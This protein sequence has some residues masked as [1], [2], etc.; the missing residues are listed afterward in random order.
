[1]C[2][3][4]KQV[5]PSKNV[6]K[7]IVES[8]YDAELYR[9]LCGEPE[10]SGFLFEPPMAESADDTETRN[11]RG[12][13]RSVMDT[14]SSYR[15]GYGCDLP[16]FGL[17][18]GE[19]SVRFG[20]GTEL[21]ECPDLIFSIADES[22][23]GLLFLG[24]FE[25]ENLY[26]RY[27][28]VIRMMESRQRGG[29]RPGPM[30]ETRV[31]LQPAFD[32]AV[33][34]SI[35]RCAAKAIFTRPALFNSIE[36][37]SALE[38]SAIGSINRNLFAEFRPTRILDD[39]IASFNRR[40]LQTLFLGNIETICDRLKIDLK[41]KLTPGIA[42]RRLL[43]ICDGHTMMKMVLGTDRNRIYEDMA[44]DLLG[45][46]FGIEFAGAL[47]RAVRGQAVHAA[48]RVRE[49][50]FTDRQPLTVRLMGQWP[51]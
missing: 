51:V 25:K 46:G 26:L 37:R 1:M 17:L 5:G 2:V 13:S 36:E 22:A 7:I 39:A 4:L 20:R 9:V 30:K 10:I 21:F 27:G 45:R 44:A 29:L 15:S 16:V 38:K 35:V 28:D 48:P 19:E 12:G 33:R 31:A 23:A 50:E 40:D 18:D 8:R 34:A 6:I 42:N 32:A 14:L 49:Q 43:S 41:D 3:E 11:S 47:L 24:C